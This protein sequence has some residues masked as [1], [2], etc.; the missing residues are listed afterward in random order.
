MHTSEPRQPVCNQV[1]QQRKACQ[2]TQQALGQQ[3]GLTRQ[4]INA[5][6]RGRYIPSVQ[7]ALLLARALDTS[8]NDLFWLSD[9]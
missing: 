7:T 1:Q 6:E 5:I 3:V 4:S 2:F 9:A 8:V